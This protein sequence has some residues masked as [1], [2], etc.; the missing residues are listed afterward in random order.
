MTCSF[1]APP[2]NRC[3]Q[4]GL[5]FCIHS[6]VWPSI[7]KEF[8]WTLLRKK[9]AKHLKY[10][11]QPHT[12]ASKIISLTS[13]FSQQALALRITLV[14]RIRIQLQRKDERRYVLG[15]DL[16]R[17]SPRWTNLLSNI[18]PI[19]SCQGLLSRSCSLIF[20]RQ[21]G[22]CV[23]EALVSVLVMPSYTWTC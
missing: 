18:G 15:C 23:L 12:I 9:M 16:S 13:G 17:W 4:N 21:R 3:T 22:G 2:A 10:I 6:R 8:S 14:Y 5:L 1:K 19:T 7:N 20:D 11:A